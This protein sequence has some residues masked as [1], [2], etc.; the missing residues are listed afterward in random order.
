VAGTVFVY[1]NSFV[2]PAYLSIVFSAMALIM[3]IL[4]GAGTLLG[5]ALGSAVIVVLENVISGHTQRWLLVL[6]L[7]YVAVTLFAPA[8]LI[9]I[10]MRR[11]AGRSP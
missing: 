3:V 6:G 7:I 11:R 10:L 4:G 8:G 2:N 9:G 1:Y 5:P